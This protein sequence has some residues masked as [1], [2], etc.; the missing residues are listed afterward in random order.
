MTECPRLLTS[1]LLMPLGAL[2]LGESLGDQSPV[3]VTSLGPPLGMIIQAPAE[4][5]GLGR[6][7]WRKE[8]VCILSW[9]QI[10]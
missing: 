7:N 4:G 6:K 2:R 9:N 5:Q 1:H 10:R 3:S 8:I